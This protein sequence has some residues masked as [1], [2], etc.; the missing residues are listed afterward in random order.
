MRVSASPKPPLA[1][2]RTSSIPYAV[3]MGDRVRSRT[4]PSASKAR[5]V[6]FMRLPGRSFSREIRER[7]RATSVIG[8]RWQTGWPSSRNAYPEHSS[9]PSSTSRTKSYDAASW[10]KHS[11]GL[12]T[13]TSPPR[14]VK[15]S[16]VNPAPKTWHRTPFARVRTPTEHNTSIAGSPLKESAQPLPV[17]SKR[18]PRSIRRDRAVLTRSSLG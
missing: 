7:M 16:S 3:S 9:N 12:T 15:Q 8:G 11:S 5:C 10:R 18:T 14:C 2:G 17:A 4:T 1:V 13:N 6:P